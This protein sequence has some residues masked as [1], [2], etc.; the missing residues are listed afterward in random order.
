M[1]VT[2]I[3]LTK[4]KRN[5]ANEMPDFYAADASEGAK[6]DYDGNDG[7]ILVMMENTGSG[8]ESVTVKAG[9][10][11]QGVRDAVFT[12]GTAVK[13]GFVLESGK[14]KVMNGENKDCILIDASANV[15]IS[16]VELP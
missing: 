1:A 12:I 10:S 9:T 11:I 4:L 8:E 2:S 14:F 6:I 13:Y 16:A 3:K 15:K 5:C 7:K